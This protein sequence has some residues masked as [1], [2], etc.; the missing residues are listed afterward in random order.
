MKRL[1][2][3][4]VLA[5]LGLAF[6]LLP[7]WG[8]LALVAGLVVA[9]KLL[10]GRLLERVALSLF[11][12]KGAALAGARARVHA[13]LP[14]PPH[15]SADEPASEARDEGLEAEPLNWRWI[16]LTIEVAEAAGEKTPFSLWDPRELMLVSPATKPGRALVR[17]T[18]TLGE[19]H[20]VELWQDGAWV[21]LDG[22]L[23][24]TQRV[25]LHAS[26]PR[27]VDRFKL[28]YYFELLEKA[29]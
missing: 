17:D 12:A 16:D 15:K 19:I 11:K 29:A 18:S 28:R 6:K 24:G 13:I 2:V 27:G 10:G 8:S 23:A 4:L 5:G 21:A 7:W 22:K 26:A 14:A 3:L 9:G 20:G 1:V 25:R